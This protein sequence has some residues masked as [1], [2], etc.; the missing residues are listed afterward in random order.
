MRHSLFSLASVVVCAECV[1][2]SM[3]RHRE[4]TDL[5]SL[6]QQDPAKVETAEDK[7]RP[8]Q[9][10]NRMRGYTLLAIEVLTLGYEY[11]ERL[12]VHSTCQSWKNFHAAMAAP[13]KKGNFA[14]IGDRLF[15]IGVY[16]GVG[17]LYLM[18]Q[19]GFSFATSLHVLGQQLST[20][21]FGAP[22][23]VP[24]KKAMVSRIFGGTA[25][26]ASKLA[27]VEAYVKPMSYLGPLSVWG[28]LFAGGLLLVVDKMKDLEEQGNKYWVQILYLYLMIITSIGLGDI[29]PTNEWAKIVLGFLYPWMTTSYDLLIGYLNKGP[30]RKHFPI[31]DTAEEICPEEEHPEG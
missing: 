10:Q 21:G 3:V 28:S 15:V 25:A 4:K 31:I 5:T 7:P 26:L 30:M 11:Y 19:D 23:E 18:Y 24:H 20:V 14:V 9:F 27:A 17:I 29:T 1:G 8:P 22:D 2:A 13:W 6:L 12:F 16:W